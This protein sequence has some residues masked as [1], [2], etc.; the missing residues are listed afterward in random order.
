MWWSSYTICGISE[1]ENRSWSSER[2]A[3]HTSQPADNNTHTQSHRCID[4]KHVFTSLMSLNITLKTHSAGGVTLIS[5]SCNNIRMC[6]KGNAWITDYFI[7]A[8]YKLYNRRLNQPVW[9][10]ILVT[11]LIKL[12]ELSFKFLQSFSYSVALCDRH[13]CNKQTCM[14]ECRVSEKVYKDK[15]GWRWTLQMTSEL[16]THAS[17]SHRVLKYDLCLCLL[18]GRKRKRL[19][20][21]HCV[22]L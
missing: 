16:N 3:K 20:L 10:G 12:P 7:D 18:Y 11:Y 14:S 1:G 19:W 9:C 8:Y 21:W 4:G 5:M 15:P 6:M 17:L 13:T 2:E 22:N